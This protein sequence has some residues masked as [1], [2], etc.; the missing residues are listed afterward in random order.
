[1]SKRG[2]RAGAQL[3]CLCWIACVIRQRSRHCGSMWRVSV[4]S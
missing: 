3:I 1:M 4:G 2:G